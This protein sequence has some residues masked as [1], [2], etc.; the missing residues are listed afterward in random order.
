ML[1]LKPWRLR[2]L[3]TAA[4]ASASDAG[5]VRAGTAVPQKGRQAGAA[6]PTVVKTK[7]GIGQGTLKRL[8][9]G[10][11]GDRKAGGKAA[12]LTGP[13]MP[14]PPDCRIRRRLAQPKTQA[15]GLADAGRMSRTTAVAHPRPGIDA[16]AL[17]R[18]TVTAAA[19]IGEQ[20]EAKVLRDCFNGPG[21]ETG[22]AWVLNRF[23]YRARI[24][25]EAEYW[26]VDSRGWVKSKESI[27]GG[28]A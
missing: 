9:T 28:V 20:P 8:R 23:S 10:A 19:P 15:L 5:P 3:A 14:E 26:S 2:A 21:V 25:L 18:P 7:I 12:R 17:A 24:E 13:T 4:P 6:E 22:I 1:Q 27:I 11:R 16:Q